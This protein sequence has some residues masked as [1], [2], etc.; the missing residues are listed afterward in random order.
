MKVVPVKRLIPKA[1]WSASRWEPT[2]TGP[3]FAPGL[4]V[5]EV[6]VNVAWPE[7]FKV[8]SQKVKSVAGAPQPSP[9]KVP[10]FIENSTAGGTGDPTG[11]PPAVATEMSGA[12]EAKTRTVPEVT[13]EP[14]I[15]QIAVTVVVVVNGPLLVGLVNW[16]SWPG[17]S[18]VTN[19]SWIALVACEHVVIG[20]GVWAA[21]G[22]T[23]SSSKPASARTTTPVGTN[24]LAN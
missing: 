18:C 22:T 12:F 10:S 21:A 24:R 15:V 23:G 20:V 4:A 7:A 19:D 14:S 6:M 13:R 9:E 11:A 16:S 3:G 5:G 1:V 2:K 17:V 8:T